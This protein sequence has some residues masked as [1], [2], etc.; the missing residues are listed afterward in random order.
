MKVIGYLVLLLAF[1]G[2]SAAEGK[3]DIGGDWTGHIDFV[4]L[5]FP[6]NLHIEHCETGFIGT[7]ECIDENAV[8]P[9]E[10][11]SFDGSCLLFE[12]P[13]IHSSYKGVL[14]NE[15]IAGTFVQGKSFPLVLKRGKAEASL[16][17]RPQLELVNQDSYKVEEVHIE[18]D[19]FT[20]AGTLMIPKG[21]GPFPAVIFIAGT[22]PHDRD[23]TILGHKPFLVIADHLAG[24]GIASLRLD[25]RGCGQSTGKYDEATC[26]DF[27]A[28][29]LDGVKYL[30]KRPE[31]KEIGLIGPSEGGTIAPEISNRSEDVDFIILLAGTGVKGS[32]VVLE[33]NR[34]FLEIAEFSKN[35]RELYLEYLRQLFDDLFQEK[36]LDKNSPK[37]TKIM[38]QMTPEFKEECTH[39]MDQVIAEIQ[40]PWFC[41]ALTYD[42]R[43]S[44]SKVNVPVLAINGSLDMQVTPEQNLYSIESLLKSGKNPPAKIVEIKGLNHLLQTAETGHPAEYARIEETISPEVLNLI[45]SWIAN[46]TGDAYSTI[47]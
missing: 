40:E 26:W 10:N 9:L 18:K 24:Q 35:D 1:N 29:T 33:Q 5:E 19:G 39:S 3:K 32:E 20:L 12:V 16:P 28:D 15:T 11:I 6:L 34:I 37:L 13:N 14:N 30:K 44:L 21:K 38:S 43:H 7:I 22:G 41:S 46:T 36:R 23:E 42:P 31:V 8:Y 47:R 4:S 45:S 27:I 25:K 17:K 2:L